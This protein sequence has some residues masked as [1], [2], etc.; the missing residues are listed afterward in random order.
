[1]ATGQ[2]AYESRVGTLSGLVLGTVGYMAPEQ[3]QGEAV[4]HRA[5][6]FSFGTILYEML[7]GQRAFRGKSDC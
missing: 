6:L 5:D 4:D 1:M 7:S 3:V 2:T